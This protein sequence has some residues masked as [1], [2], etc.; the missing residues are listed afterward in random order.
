MEKGILSHC[1][2]IIKKIKQINR[3]VIIT[4]QQV[5]KLYGLPLL[6]HLQD[7]G[8]TAEIL[9]FP[10]G[11]KFKNEN[12]KMKLDHQLLKKKYGRDTMI[13]ALGGGVAG[14]MAGFIASTYMRGIPYIQV[15]TSLLAMADSS[16]GAKVSVNTPYGK[17][18][19]GAFWKPEAVIIDLSCLSTLSQKHFLHGFFE[20]I[21]IFL[22]SDQKSF[23]FVQKN[24]TKI[25]KRD[26]LLIE[27]TIKQAITLKQN[28]VA[29]DERENSKRMM[30]NF[31]HTIG[32][33]LEHISNYRLL[34]GFAVALGMMV[35]SKISQILGFLPEKDYDQIEKF[36]QQLGIEKK[37]LRQFDI[38]HIIRATL[39]DKKVYSKKLRYVLL[40]RPGAVKI[41]KGQYAH[42]V[43]PAKIKKAFYQLTH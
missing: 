4:D 34:H 25:L 6:Q 17:N 19:I 7:N 36:L 43:D 16:I 13:L 28:I 40:Q 3:Y 24:Y 26:A 18:L 9:A 27:K 21:K 37:I 10:A 33:A 5:K 11:E 38:N 32:H 14:D 2:S 42:P 39:H 22:V 31:G 1:A 12:V 20:I 35:E 41:I 30:I 23:N 29:G 8:F 15:P